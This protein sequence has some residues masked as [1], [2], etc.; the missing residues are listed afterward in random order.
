MIETSVKCP[1]GPGKLWEKCLS[2]VLSSCPPLEQAG[3]IIQLSL[4]VRTWQWQWT[5]VQHCRACFGKWEIPR[6]KWGSWEQ[7]ALRDLPGR[8]TTPG[9]YVKVVRE[10]KELHSVNTYYEPDSDTRRDSS[11]VVRKDTGSGI[12]SL[13]IT[14]WFCHYLDWQF[15]AGYGILSKAQTSVSKL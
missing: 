11:W 3:S 7:T 9:N 2:G 4:Q 12:W 14:P 5:G 1:L 15:W 13:E 10:R 8:Q 6:G